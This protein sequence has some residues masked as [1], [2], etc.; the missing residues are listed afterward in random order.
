MTLSKKP[1]RSGRSCS[2]PQL[3][4]KNAGVEVKAT[5][6]LLLPQLNLFGEYQAS[7]LDGVFT[8]TVATGAF[9]REPG[10]P[11]F[12]PGDVVPDGTI[13][14]G[15]VPIGISGSPITVPGTPVRSGLAGDLNGMIRGRYP[16]FEGGL[17]LTLPIRNRA[18]QANNATAQLNRARAGSSASADPKYDR[19]ECP[20]GP[21]RAR[22]GPRRDYGRRG[23]SSLRT[24]KL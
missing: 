16:T 14:A 23:S 19:A 17:N 18:A 15:T 5:R 3:N 20:P 9:C 13:P 24:A 1:G 6:N 21:D 7:G 10:T 12:L 4:L 22:T 2:R 11:I 8:P